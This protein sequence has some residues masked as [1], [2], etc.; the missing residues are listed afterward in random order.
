MYCGLD[1]KEESKKTPFYPADTIRTVERIFMLVPNEGLK[2][3][4]SEEEKENYLASGAS[5][6]SVHAPDGYYKITN[7]SLEFLNKESLGRGL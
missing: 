7:D 3:V 1:G 2:E 6:Y 5:V 4:F